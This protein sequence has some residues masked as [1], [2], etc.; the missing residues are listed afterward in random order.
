MKL[1]T[2]LTLSGLGLVLM[3][4][5]A[6]DHSLPIACVGP[7]PDTAAD[8]VAAKGM[9]MVYSAYTVTADFDRRDIHRPEYSDYRLLAADGTALQRVANTSGTIL[10]RPKLVALPPGQYRVVA[11]ASGY[12][13]VT[14]P[15]RIQAGQTTIVHLQ[16]GVAWP[17]QPEFT[18]AN[19]VRL[20]NGEIVGWKSDVGNN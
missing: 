1:E 18:S 3:G 11:C 6:S 4:C 7:A 2:F 15:V 8:R 9:L 13:W 19:A 12:G 10:Q 17:G 20:P 5:A 16:G 14:V